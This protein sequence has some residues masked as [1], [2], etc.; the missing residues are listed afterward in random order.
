MSGAWARPRK[1][2]AWKQHTCDWCFSAI[3]RGEVYTYWFGPSDDGEMAQ[4][5]THNDCWEAMERE[6]ADSG[7]WE[8]IDWWGNHR[9]GMTTT[10]T[11]LAP[12]EGEDAEFS[13]VIGGR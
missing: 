12:Y 5:R 2:N 7:G 13:Q 11:E 6:A 1:H 3:L 10:E 8:D 9:R 4:S